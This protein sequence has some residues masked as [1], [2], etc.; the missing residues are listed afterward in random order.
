M[1]GGFV[2]GGRGR[3]AGDL[4]LRIDAQPDMDQ[5]LVEIVSPT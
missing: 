4:P 5:H 1:P 2:E 3:A